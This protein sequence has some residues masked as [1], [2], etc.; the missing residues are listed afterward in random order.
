MRHDLPSSG[1]NY[2]ALVVIVL[3]MV[4][5]V[6]FFTEAEVLKCMDMGNMDMLSWFEVIEAM[7]HEWGKANEV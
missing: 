3:S 6:P 7:C 5:T 1:A 4:H 2:G